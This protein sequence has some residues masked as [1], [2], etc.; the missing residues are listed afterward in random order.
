MKNRYFKSH[1][2]PTCQSILEYVLILA[3]A[4]VGLTIFS[5]QLMQR[6]NVAARAHRETALQLML[7]RGQWPEG[8]RPLE[9]LREIEERE[10]P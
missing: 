10:A 3:L 9:H 6:S 1:N 5:S 8:V 4:V 7:G 2:Q